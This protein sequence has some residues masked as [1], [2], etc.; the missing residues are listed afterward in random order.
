MNYKQPSFV[1]CHYFNGVLFVLDVWKSEPFLHSSC[2]SPVQVSISKNYLLKIFLFL[3]R[4]KLKFCVKLSKNKVPLKR[5]SNNFLLVKLI[6]NLHTASGES[7][8]E[9][10]S[11]RVSSRPLITTLR[12]QV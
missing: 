1:T 10:K 4:K 2:S 6:R 8:K 3:C 9:T 5:D 12:F 7:K 11:K